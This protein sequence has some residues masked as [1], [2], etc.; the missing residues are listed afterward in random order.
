[1]DA[2]W[3]RCVMQSTCLHLDISF[4]LIAIFFAA[5][6]DTPVS[7]SSKIRVS[8]LSDKIDFRAS[9]VL[10][11][12]PPDAIFVKGLSGSPLFVLIRN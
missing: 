1:M 6:P 2:S 9:I 12:S 7:I 4:S 11:S 3:G 10:E 8:T 5:L